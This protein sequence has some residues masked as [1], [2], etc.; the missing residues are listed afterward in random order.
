[1]IVLLSAAELYKL[2]VL[3]CDFK[4]D[5]V[6]SEFPVHKNMHS[7]ELSTDL[8]NIGDIELWISVSATFLYEWVVVWTTDWPLISLARH[9]NRDINIK[10]YDDMFSF[11]P[12]I[13]LSSFTEN[14]DFIFSFLLFLSSCFYIIIYLLFGFIHAN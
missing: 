13:F 7:I 11:D 2:H 14:A 1:M 8:V 4:T 9:V 10:K 6:H 5:R 12:F 3:L